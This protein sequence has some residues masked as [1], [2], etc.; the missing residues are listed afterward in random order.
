MTVDWSF[1][2]LFLAVDFTAVLFFFLSPFLAWCVD[3]KCV[4]IC[5]FSCSLYLYLP[6]ITC[7]LP[8]KCHNHCGM[9]LNCLFELRYVFGKF[10]VCCYSRREYLLLFL[11]V[12]K[13]P[14]RRM[15]ASNYQGN[16][17]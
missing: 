11:V 16:F 3:F 17:N 4:F 14:L 1:R 13:A 12:V 9:T 5:L 6:D 2:L 7:E 15:G 10:L 8:P